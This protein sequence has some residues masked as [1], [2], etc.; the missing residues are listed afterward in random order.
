MIEEADEGFLISLLGDIEEGVCDLTVIRIHEA[1][2]FGKGL[3]GCKAVIPGSGKILSFPLK[4]I[5]EGED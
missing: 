5:E 1:D 2:H 4:G 3:D